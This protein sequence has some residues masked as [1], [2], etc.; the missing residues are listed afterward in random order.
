MRTVF[1]TRLHETSRET[2]ETGGQHR[3]SSVVPSQE[4]YTYTSPWRKYDRE[5]H[6]LV[7]HSSKQW[8]GMKGR[9]ADLDLLLRSTIRG[10]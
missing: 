6:S 1:F 5:D 10:V 2:G 7:I 3:H 4:K 8:V 9:A